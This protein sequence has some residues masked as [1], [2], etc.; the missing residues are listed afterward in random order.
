ASEFALPISVGIQLVNHDRAVHAAVASQI[1]L[2]ITIDIKL[3]DDEAARRWTLPDARVNGFAAPR[4]IA[5]QTDVNRHKPCWQ[6]PSQRFANVPQ[7]V[8]SAHKNFSNAL[9]KRQRVE[10]VGV[11][12]FSLFEPQ[13]FRDEDAVQ[14][15]EEELHQQ[16]EQGSGNCALKIVPES[17]RLSP[18]IIGS[19][20][21]PTP[22]SA[23]S[24]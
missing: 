5:W 13:T 19:P 16:C 10:W 11:S 1:S 24:V 4:D 21:P 9:S 2:A 17:F 15:V 3:S 18:L 23:A 20:N 14:S 12:N 6:F 8:R 22:M 7:T